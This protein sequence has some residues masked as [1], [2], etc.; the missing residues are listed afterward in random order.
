MR[1]RKLLYLLLSAW[2]LV[3]GMPSKPVLGQTES[4][5]APSGSA[6]G[7][8][9]SGGAKGA[10]STGA[11]S[12]PAAGA[13]T[14]SGSSS[15]PAQE[16][17]PESRPLKQ[18]TT[19]GP[20]QAPVEGGGL[21]QDVLGKL[22]MVVAL[23][24]VCAAVWKK[25]QAVQPQ[26]PALAPNGLQV[27]TS[28]PLGAQRYVHV[29]AAGRRHYLIGSSPQSVTLLATLDDE[30]GPP[31]APAGASPGYSA[32]AHGQLNARNESG[33]AGSWGDAEGDGGDRFEELLLRLRRLE[34]EQAPRGRPDAGYDAEVSHRGRGAASSPEA[35][36]ERRVRAS[37]ESRGS[38]DGTSDGRALAPG[39]LFRNASDGPR[40]GRYA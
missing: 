29:V 7:V 16:D 26:N 5:A 30:Y 8:A 18:A 38:D 17:D 3:I 20:G 34:D 37:H 27:V 35:L 21:F 4:G 14:N 39:S 33:T 28:L 24:L 10:D 22:A 15:V 40:G 36:P 9:D 32:S 25:L 2:L 1:A 19:T 11:A 31:G 12:P 13:A 6:G 23:I